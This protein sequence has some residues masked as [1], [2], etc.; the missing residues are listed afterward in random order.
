MP[1]VFNYTDTMDLS[2]VRERRRSSKPKATMRKLASGLESPGR[3]PAASYCSLLALIMTLCAA[4]VC[5]ASL[6]CS[7]ALRQELVNNYH[8]AFDRLTS[9][10]SRLC[11]A[12]Q[13][14]DFSA[15]DKVLGE[16]LVGQAEA[17][18]A[19]L[20]WFRQANAVPCRFLALHGSTGTGK[21][22]AVSIIAHYYPWPEKVFHVMW[23]HESSPDAQYA[24]FQST[25][26]EMRQK[27]FWH[28]I[29]GDYLLVVDHLGPGDVHQLLADLSEQLVTVAEQLQIKLNVL[30]AFRGTPANQPGS[31]A[32]EQVIPN[33]EIVKFS[34]LRSEELNDCIRR[35]GLRLGFTAG[36]QLEKAIATVSK[37]IDVVR[38][39]CKPVRAKLNLALTSLNAV[40]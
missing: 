5:L 20:Q 21:S 34:A 12:R 25:L 35:E 9:E 6:L 8:R 17:H 23:R 28:G 10:S 7:P 22:L 31:Q 14:A 30:L 18:R 27:V 39:G 33:M 29:C 40:A 36:Q 4:S 37:Q 3:K 15:M 32:L 13:A 16:T 38:H 24:A 19:I 2:T 11:S 26:T 1:F